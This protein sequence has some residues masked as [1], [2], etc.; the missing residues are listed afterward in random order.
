MESIP[1]VYNREFNMNIT[2]PFKAEAEVG[3][4]MYDMHHPEAVF[5]NE[6]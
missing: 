3:Y 5:A 4:N 1:E 6:A 2:V